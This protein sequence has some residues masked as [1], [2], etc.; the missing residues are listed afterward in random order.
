MPLP[1]SGK[2]H[3]EHNIQEE[4][5]SKNK[6]EKNFAVFCIDKFAHNLER[7]SKNNKRKDSPGQL[8]AQSY[9]APDKTL[10]RVSYEKGE[11]ESAPDRYDYAGT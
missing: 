7:G 4:D 10:K 2:L 6:P 1:G 11:K 8:N 5:D 9:L 3:E